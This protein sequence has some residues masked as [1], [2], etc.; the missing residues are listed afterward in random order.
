MPQ[1]E[2]VS[3][4]FQSSRRVGEMGGFKPRYFLDAAGHAVP[5]GH[6]LPVRAVASARCCAACASG[7]RGQLDDRTRLLL[8]Q[9]ARCRSLLFTADQLALD[10]QDQ[11]AGAGLLVADRSW[12]CTTCCS[13]GDGCGAWRGGWRRRRRS[14]WPPASWSAMP[15]LPIAGDLNSWSGWK[16][17]AA[18][19]RRRLARAARA[20]GQAGL[21][22][23]AELQDQLAAALLPARP[24]AHLCAGHLRRRARCSSTTSRSTRDLKGATGILVLSDQDAVATW[25]WSA[26]RHTS[27]RSNWS[28]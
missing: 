12:A 2:W 20:E 10:R 21:R 18:A 11:L 17:A 14:C 6:A 23:L 7:S 25:T 8:H 15:N 1:H 19:R 16:E 13:A 28:T 26:W 24:A 4:A 3:F 27:T 9:R 22:L 5:A